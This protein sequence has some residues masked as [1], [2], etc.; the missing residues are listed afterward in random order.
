MSVALVRNDSQKS[1]KIKKNKNKNYGQDSQLLK[2]S[3]VNSPI[4]FFSLLRQRSQASFLY[5]KQQQ[6]KHQCMYLMVQ[7]LYM[8]T[9]MLGSRS[10]LPF[11][12]RHTSQTMSSW[13]EKTF[14]KSSNFSDDL[15]SESSDPAESNIFSIRPLISSCEIRVFAISIIDL[16]IGYTTCQK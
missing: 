6:L 9:P 15:R 3:F 14:A 7:W 8:R 4:I 2:Q 1:H 10:W 5:Q 11:Q 12:S 13:S 16:R